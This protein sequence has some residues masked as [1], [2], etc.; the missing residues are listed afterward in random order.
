MVFVEMWQILPKDV[1]TLE[2]SAFKNLQLP[3]TRENCDQ[4]T[5]IIARLYHEYIQLNV[6]KTGNS[7]Q[8]TNLTVYWFLNTT[9]YQH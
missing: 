5:D 7:Y 9:S 8:R 4:T 1:H 2:G 6:S 3:V